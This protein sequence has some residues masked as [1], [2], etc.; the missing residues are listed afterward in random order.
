MSRTVVEKTIGDLIFLKAKLYNGILKDKLG[1][2]DEAIHALEDLHQFRALGTIEELQ[3]KMN[4]LE[5]LYN[6]IQPNEMEYHLA[7]YRASSEKGE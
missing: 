3:E 7:S 1:C 6:H 2:I 4:F 5:Y